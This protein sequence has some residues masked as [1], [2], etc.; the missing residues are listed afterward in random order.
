MKKMTIYQFREEFAP[1]LVENYHTGLYSDKAYALYK[2]LEAVARGENCY[3]SLWSLSMSDGRLIDFNGNHRPVYGDGVLSFCRQFAQDVNTVVVE[4]T[5]EICIE[6]S[7]HADSV[8]IFSRPTADYVKTQV[9]NG[10]L[11]FR[12]WLENRKLAED[13]PLK[14]QVSKSLCGMLRPVGD[15]LRTS[16]YNIEYVFTIDD[17]SKMIDYYVNKREDPSVVGCPNDPILLSKNELW[18]KEVEDVK[19]KLA[20]F[21]LST[22]IDTYRKFI[23]VLRKYDGTLCDRVEKIAKAD[24]FIE[25]KEEVKSAMFSVVDV[26]DMKFF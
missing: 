2:V 24:C 7:I 21:P 6:T 9:V 25:S 14:M 4:P 10:L 26:S 19:Q 11:E 22:S 15:N 12:R 13:A 8:N 17:V 1:L 16:Y 23:S 20:N 5:G 3:T 18:K